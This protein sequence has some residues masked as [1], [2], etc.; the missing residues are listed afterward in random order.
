M[1]KKILYILA[2]VVLAGGVA[3]FEVKAQED[4][5]PKIVS[6]NESE[7]VYGNYYATGDQIEI[8]GTIN[9]DAYVF[10]GQIIVNGVVNGDLIA[11]G[12]SINVS[13]EVQEDARLAA[14]TVMLSGKI[15]KNL[16]VAGGEITLV[17]NSSVGGGAQVAGGSIVISGA[18]GRELKGAGG[19]FNLTSTANI[20]GNFDYI[21]EEPANISQDTTVAGATRK[22]G[23]AKLPDEQKLAR[24]FDTFARALSLS[25]LIT[26]LVLGILLLKLAPRLVSSGIQVVETQTLKA[27][28]IGLAT[29]VLVPILAV[30]LAITLVGIPLAIIML[31]LG[32]ILVMV[33]KIYA[34]TAIGQWLLAK[35]KQK[36]NLWLSFFVGMAMY[37]LLLLMPFIGIFIRFIALTVGAGALVISKKNTYNVMK[38][39]KLI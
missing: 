14:G 29:F 36:Q 13:G 27:F 10:G 33:G 31:F 16:S 38:T 39:Q 37:S 28:L 34:V 24:L 12:G 23:D 2:L 5:S 22:H 30:V 32:L 35:S 1:S 17:N 20:G 15:G 6:L 8:A 19:L 7:V 18:I 21:S 25:G 26:S 3:A 9:G 4:Q 11:A